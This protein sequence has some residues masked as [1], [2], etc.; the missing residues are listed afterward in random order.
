LKGSIREKNLSVSIL[1]IFSS[2]ASRPPATKEENLRGKMKDTK[3]AVVV[4]VLILIAL[5]PN[6]LHGTSKLTGPVVTASDTQTTTMTV[7]I[8]P[9]DVEIN[10]IETQVGLVADFNCT[11][12]ILYWSNGTKDIAISVESLSPELHAS[13][14]MT[15]RMNP[16]SPQSQLVHTQGASPQKFQY[17]N[18]TYV[19]AGLNV[20]IGNDTVDIK[21]DMPDVWETYG[22]HSPHKKRVINGT[23]ARHIYLSEENM[24]KWE[25]AVQEGYFKDM[26]FLAFTGGYMSLALTI[27]AYAYTA[28]TLAI[29]IAITALVVALW[30]KWLDNQRIEKQQWF[31]DVVETYDHGGVIRVTNETFWLET[32]YDF[33]RVTTVHCYECLISYGSDFS[34][35]HYYSQVESLNYASWSLWTQMCI[36]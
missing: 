7:P 6:L 30:E 13:G 1:S 5:T 28:P 11:T 20:D 16:K 23:T 22:P 9:I 26:T 4:F 36:T 35:Q 29:A 17:D 32:C 12:T 18:V 25:R 14:T 24:T 10:G 15:S 3:K 19:K 27:M 21:Y 33:F 2:E 34:W 31:E 8:G